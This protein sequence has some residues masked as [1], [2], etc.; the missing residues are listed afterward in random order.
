MSDRL[1]PFLALPNHHPVFS[2]ASLFP[3]QLVSPCAYSIYSTAEQETILA[4]FRKE[5][6][7]EGLIPADLEEAK[8][9]IGYD[10]FD[11]KT[12]L[13]FLR[14]RKFDI[15]KAKLMW[16]NN[17]KWRKEFGTDEIAKCVF[18]CESATLDRG[19]WSRRQS[20][21]PSPSVLFP[22]CC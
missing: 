17:E 15:P 1:I 9:R 7:E 6:T 2:T 16:E 18:G 13:R 8:E 21:G 19:R 14:A 20:S 22:T 11:D 3:S 10:R 5:L 4:Q 12:L